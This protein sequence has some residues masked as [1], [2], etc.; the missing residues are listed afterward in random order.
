[1]KQLLFL[2]FFIILLFS[3]GKNDD[4]KCTDEPLSTG[5]KIWATQ[6]DDFYSFD[7]CKWIDMGKSLVLINDFSAFESI[8]FLIDKETGEIKNSSL[9]DFS[10]YSKVYVYNDEFI[11]ENPI[12]DIIIYNPYTKT[13]KTVETGLNLEGFSVTGNKIIYAGYPYVDTLDVIAMVDINTMQTDV[14]FKNKYNSNDDNINKFRDPFLYVSQE[15]DSLIYFVTHK[16]NVSSQSKLNIYNLETKELRTKENNSFYLYEMFT[17]KNN[18]FYLSEDRFMKLN[19]QNLNVVWE[20]KF[21]KY[22]TLYKATSIFMPNNILLF[23][24]HEAIFIDRKTGKVHWKE[25]SFNYFKGM[26]N[27]IES[28]KA[29]FLNDKLYLKY[30]TGEVKFL[31]VNSGEYSQYY[32]NSPEILNSISNWYDNEN[33]LYYI[34]Y[35][36]KVVKYKQE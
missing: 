10:Y 8:V 20:T 27:Y 15:N 13:S 29:I 7:R 6:L 31:D 25:E 36:K 17:E 28:E 30:E 3:C 19:P 34:S 14:I 24:K 1:M 22:L 2:S 21:S 16:N 4:D 11:Y 26:D 23:N 12:S 5:Q 18:L 32:C 33:N 9:L 35:D